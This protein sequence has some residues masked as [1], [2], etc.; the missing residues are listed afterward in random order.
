MEGERVE[1]ERVEGQGVK[2]ERV[3]GQIVEFHRLPEDEN[4]EAFG[5]S[6]GFPTDRRSCDAQRAIDE[7]T[8]KA[9]VPARFASFK[10]RV[11]W[12]LS[13]EEKEWVL[14]VLNTWKDIFLVDVR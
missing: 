1:G 13:A 14:R 5:S 11:G 2:G 4:D 8:P 9:D 12:H 3:E 6:I 7:S 10:L